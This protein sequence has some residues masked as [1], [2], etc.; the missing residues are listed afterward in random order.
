MCH[1]CLS[2]ADGDDV[3][4]WKRTT[5]L[6]KESVFHAALSTSTTLTTVTAATRSLSMPLASARFVCVHRPCWQNVKFY[7]RPF[8]LD[9]KRLM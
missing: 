4:G 1:D 3:L 9:L 6:L 8:C 5:R 2:D 7:R